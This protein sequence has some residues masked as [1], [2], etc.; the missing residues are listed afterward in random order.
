MGDPDKAI[1]QYLNTLNIDPK[2]VD[3]LYN[4]GVTWKKL[5]KFKKAIKCYDNVLKINPYF[6]AAITNRANCKWELGNYKSSQKDYSLAISIDK[7]WVSKN[8]GEKINERL[9]MKF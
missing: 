4:L 1:K 2:D 8:F 6:L 3:A 7:E 9:N 5:G